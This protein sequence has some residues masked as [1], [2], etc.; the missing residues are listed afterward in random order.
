MPD[1]FLKFWKRVSCSPIDFVLILYLYLPSAGMAG[2]HH[3]TLVPFV[4]KLVFGHHAREWVLLWSFGLSASLYLVLVCPLHF[5]LI[6]MT[7]H[8]TSKK[9]LIFGSWFEN[10]VHDGRVIMGTG[11]WGSRSPGSAAGSRDRWMLSSASMFVTFKFV[12]CAVGW[13]RCVGTTVS[14]WWLGTKLSASAA[15]TFTCS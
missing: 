14:M 13:V 6:A 7:N 11:A 3:H 12:F 4:F 10:T 8:L 2:M 1:L 9:G 15:A 5:F